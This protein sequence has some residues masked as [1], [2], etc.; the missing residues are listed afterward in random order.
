MRDVHDCD[1]ETLRKIDLRMSALRARRDARSRGV[2]AGL[3]LNKKEAPASN[4]K[5]VGMRAVRS[6][7]EQVE[8]EMRI[9]KYRKLA[10]RWHS[11]LK[12]RNG[13]TALLQNWN[14][15]FVRYGKGK[16]ARA[17][18][19]EQSRWRKIVA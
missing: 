19:R 12:Q 15:N 10:R 11:I 13:S 3:R 16:W 17:G 18:A 1:I 7:N 2:G 9:L 5:G 6:K 14:R 4:K 8:L